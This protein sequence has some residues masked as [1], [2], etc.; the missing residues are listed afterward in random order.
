MKRL[1][2]RFLTLSTL[3]IVTTALFAHPIDFKEHLRRTQ[4]LYN[5]GRWV[6]A[7]HHAESALSEL[8]SDE[9]QEREALHFYLAACTYELKGDAVQEILGSFIERYPH[10]IY[11][12]DIQFM[13]AAYHSSEDDFESAAKAFEEVDYEALN[14]QQQEKYDIRVGYIEFLSENYG[15]AYNYFERISPK[16]DYYDHA[17]YYISYID[18][19]NGEMASAKEGFQALTKSDVYG[20][21]APYYL[22]QIEFKEG[23]YRYVVDNSSALIATLQGE[24]LS[25]LERCTAEAWFRLGDYA[26]SLEHVRAYEAA[27]GVAGR[28]ESY[29]T[30]FS[31]YKLGDYQAAAPHLRAASGAE[32]ALT[33]NA[34]YHLADCYLRLGDKHSAMQAFAMSAN[35]SHN[36]KI[37]EDALFN[38]AKLQYELGGGAFNGAINLL[39]RY[40]ESYPESERTPQARE[41]LVAAY[42]NSNDYTA[43]YEAIKRLPD[44]DGEF[45]GALQKIA[46]FRALEAFKAGD[47]TLAKQYLVESAAIKVVA[48]YT[49]LSN[50]WQGEIAFAEGEYTIAMAKYNA[51]LR[52]APRSEREYALA[53]YNLGYAA[54]MREN[55]EQAQS[56]FEQFVAVY[57]PRD[58]YLSDAYNRLGDTFY[59]GR[60]FGKAVENYDKATLL[61]DENRYY[62]EYKRAV[63]LGVQGK[64]KEKEQALKQIIVTGEGD[65]VDDASFELGRSY[66][67]Q[68][69]Y[70]EGAK[71]LESFIEEYPLSPQRQ[72]ALSNLGLAH[73]N[74][75]NQTESL[76]YYDMVVNSSPQSTQAKEAM[77][78]IRN[79]YVEKG[80]VAAYFDYAAKVGV[81]S[82]TTA[83]SRDS[84]TFAAAQRL[85]LVGDAKAASRSLK[86]Y[87]DGFPKG[88]HIDDALFYLS[89]CYL[90]LDEREQAI[91]ALTKLSQSGSVQYSEATLDKLSALCYDEGQYLQAMDAYRRLYDVASTGAKKQ[92]AMLGYMRSAL[93]TED[94]SA[95]AVAAADVIARGDGA[96]AEALRIARYTRATQLREAGKSDEAIALYVALAQDLNSKEGSEAAYW[97]VEH[98]YKSGDMDKT[99][100]QIFT[101]SER[102][103]DAYWLARAFI[104]LGDVYVAKGDTFQA[105]ATYQSVADGYTPSD[106]GIVDEAKERILKLN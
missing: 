57:Q 60:E 83:L 103:I 54:M 31:L 56:Q 4:E 71:Q 81:E 27:G 33:Q 59:S 45:R 91:D 8:Q 15:K 19:I 100:K 11:A 84:L 48:K 46:Y 37:T 106:D 22:L 32:D 52:Q 64:T 94:T 14:P 99:E 55:Y 36:A 17:L 98:T 67:A 68:E 61:G 21:L 40:I 1:I 53:L 16:S 23:N 39:T 26:K 97:L 66:I 58:G 89:D 95:I 42:Y 41:L 75:G 24:R 28:E 63:S 38:Y 35:S 20:D 47:L 43:A 2:V 44:A 105:R 79:I 104:L 62:A 18:Y 30:G 96:G 49:A 92:G 82:D 85:Y 86:S 13:M 29:I 6:E 77:Q 87:V 50:F 93:A 76:R 90:R 65:Y 5:E 72:Q 73:L 101:L 69:R 34:S 70:S 80:D 7:R 10:S 78:G 3:L 51:Y 88:Y 102:K 12:N 9:V 25:E 74:L